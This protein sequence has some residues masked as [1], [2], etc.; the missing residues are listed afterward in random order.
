M[1]TPMKVRNGPSMANFRDAF[2]FLMG[3]QDSNSVEVFNLES[4][5]WR[6]APEMNCKRANA[7][8]CAQDRKVYTF[9]GCSAGSLTDYLN[10]IECI[11]AA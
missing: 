6:R 9:G 3:G 7:S 1:A 8:S 4:E 11:D 5:E 10:S 2:I